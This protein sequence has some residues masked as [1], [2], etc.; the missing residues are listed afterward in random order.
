M[1]C[2]CPGGRTL[3]VEFGKEF[4]MRWIYT[5]TAFNEPLDLPTDLPE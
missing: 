2:D 5:L 3:A 1:K 4:L